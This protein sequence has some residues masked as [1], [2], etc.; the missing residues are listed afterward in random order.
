MNF[1]TKLIHNTNDKDKITGALSIP[2]Y[3]V[4]TYH[5]EDIEAEQEYQ[6]S[7]SENPT[8]RAIEETIAE[9]ENGDRGF[10]FSSGMAAT[11]SVLSI[12][13]AGDHII[14]CQDVYGGTYRALN[15]IFNRYGIEVS[16]VDT[17]DLGE[18]EANIKE[19][20]RA[21]FLETPSNPTL[22]ITN[23]KGAVGI[24][25]AHHL[26]V[27]VDNTFMTP[28]LQRPLDLGAD[29][30]IHSATKFIGGHS[31]VV[32]GL[33]AVKG[34][35]LSE[36]LYMI[37]NGFGA[38]LGPQDSWLLLRGLKTLKVRMDYQQKNAEELAQWLSNHEKIQKVYYPG[39]L[40]HQNREIHDTQANGAGAVM[41]FKTVEIETAQKFMKMVKLAAVAVS[42]G[43]VETIASYPVKMS[44]AAMP[45]AQRESLGIT[46]NLIRLSVG[47]EDI[48]DLI[49]DFDKALAGAE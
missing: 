17:T 37:Q 41:S 36:R 43:G 8:R 29:I 39:L 48:K 44:H 16:L 13:S 26:L 12:F 5:Q 18:I 6:Y 30:V 40:G 24:A 14:A 47:L 15:R 23:L 3:Q 11:S 45:K 19:N 25:K 33:V 21:I 38:V 22:K 2:I 34:K 32:A 28:Y 9:L 20:T 4:S 7:R 49:E 10:A 42:L 46:E 35:A 27:I 31:D 1:G